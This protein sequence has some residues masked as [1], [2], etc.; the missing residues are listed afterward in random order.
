METTF[1]R[2]FFPPP[3]NSWAD[4]SVGALQA[5]LEQAGQL[6]VLFIF[7]GDSAL[8]S[9]RA[10][11]HHYVSPLPTAAQRPRRLPAQLNFYD[12]KNIFVWVKIFD[13]GCGGHC[14]AL[15]WR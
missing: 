2:Q 6:T 11:P 13:A 14:G 12:G 1:A 5:G 7:S 3:G 10:A 9:T 4:L 8:V 15:A